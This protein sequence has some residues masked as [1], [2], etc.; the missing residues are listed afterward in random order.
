MLCDSPEPTSELGGIVKTNL[1]L[2]I[3][4]DP[5]QVALGVGLSQSVCRA[6]KELA[7]YG[8]RKLM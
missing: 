3:G 5:H 1:L 4:C 8:P 2:L 7:H 6:N